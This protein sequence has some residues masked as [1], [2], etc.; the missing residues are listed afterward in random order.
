MVRPKKRIDS[1][2]RIPLFIAPATSVNEKQPHRPIFVKKIS[3][4]SVSVTHEKTNRLD[5]N[6]A[7][8][9][10]GAAASRPR[11]QN[12]VPRHRVRGCK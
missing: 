9:E 12:T 1:R 6:V 10:C 3:V 11:M 5:T 8:A 4:R 2:T 7:N